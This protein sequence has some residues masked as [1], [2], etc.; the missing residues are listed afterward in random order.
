MPSSVPRYQSPETRAWKWSVTHLMDRRPALWAWVSFV[1]AGLIYSFWWGVHVD[2][3]QPTH[4][5]WNTATDLWDT[6]QVATQV[7]HGHL[8]MYA[9]NDF[10]TFP[11][12]AFLL[13]PVGA[14]VSAGHLSVDIVPYQEWVHPQAWALLDPVLLLL[15]AV[16][17]FAFDALAQR[18]GVSEPKRLVLAFAQGVALWSVVVFWGHPE[19]AVAIGFMAY[20][21]LFFFDERWNGSAWLFGIAVAFQPL[22]LAALP[23]VLS[24][25]G[26]RRWGGYLQRAAVPGVVVL[27]G[28]LI[29]SFHETVSALV[30]QPN[31]PLAD[32]QTPWTALAPR[33]HIGVVA[34]AA[35]PGRLVSLALACGI[36]WWSLRWR[37]RGPPHS[38][39]PFGA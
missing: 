19:D 29:A 3:V 37:G 32:H 22:V 23:I 26:V 1:V 10:A 39:S 9:R 2:W 6:L 28:P 30:Q 5:N 18:L 13:A 35:G 8:S 7:A 17:L 12:I 21:F 25:I 20:A 36:G 33:V 38:P 34:V 31:Y 16:P 14:L 27:L 4:A 15:G 24:V 11:G